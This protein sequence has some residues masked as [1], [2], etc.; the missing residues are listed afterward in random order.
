MFFLKA[1]SRN[2]AFGGVVNSKCCCFLSGPP[3]ALDW[4]R[5][6]V[7]YHMY[8]EGAAQEEEEKVQPVGATVQL[9]WFHLS[10]DC[11][12]ARARSFRGG[13]S[14]IDHGCINWSSYSG[15]MCT[16]EKNNKNGML[17][18]SLIIDSKGTKISYFFK[19]INKNT[20]PDGI[21]EV[22]FMGSTKKAK[23]QTT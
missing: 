22:S 13:C 5:P 14:P 17:K 18:L 7:Y 20:L 23:A 4:R 9:H 6:G 2:D 10:G 3:R 16:D 15:H 12:R 1:T 8:R 19:G 21:N 11:T